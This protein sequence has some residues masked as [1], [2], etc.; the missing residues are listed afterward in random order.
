[1]STGGRLSTQKNPRSSR[2][3]T[4]IVLPAPDMPVM[5]TSLGVFVS[6]CCSSLGGCRNKSADPN[7]AP[8]WLRLLGAENESGRADD[9]CIVAQCSGDDLHAFLGLVLRIFGEHF[10]D[11]IEQEIAGLGDASADDEALRIQG[12]SGGRHRPAQV[13]G[14]AVH[15]AGRHLVARF[16]GV[17]DF[18]GHDVGLERQRRAVAALHGI[19]GHADDAGGGG[20][21]LQAAGFAASALDRFQIGHDRHVAE[22]SGH[23]AEAFIDAAVDDDSAPYAGAERVA[24][25]VRNAA[26]R[27]GPSFAES[28]DIGVVVD[29]DGLV[30]LLFKQLLER[31]VAYIQIVGEL[32]DAIR[33]VQETCDPDADSAYLFPGKARLADDMAHVRHNVVHDALCALGSFRRALIRPEQ[34]AHRAANSN[35]DGGAADIRSNVDCF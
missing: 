29:L 33:D 4:A 28:G 1:M 26:A 2:L 18:L 19:L 35:F 3:W 15:D 12:D 7:P 30:Q 23:A 31:H 27:S 32:H 21:R 9:A 10:A 13:I 34:I 5:M 22:L 11:L 25:A 17:D 6:I 8:G 20:Y 16:G 24:D 14:G